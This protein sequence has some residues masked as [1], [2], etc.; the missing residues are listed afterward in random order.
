MDDPTVAPACTVPHHSQ[1]VA[2]AEIAAIH[3]RG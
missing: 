1:L 3:L 2:N